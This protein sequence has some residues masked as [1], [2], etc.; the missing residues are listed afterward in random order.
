MTTSH[1]MRPLRPHAATSASYPRV[2]A[3]AWDDIAD[4]AACGRMVARPDEARPS[5][6]SSRGDED[7]GFAVSDFPNKTRCYTA[8]ARDNGDSPSRRLL[9]ENGCACRA[10]APE[11]IGAM[12]AALAHPARSERCRSAIS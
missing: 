8:R 9:H 3:R 12:Q 6:G 2:C 7:D 5:D 11:N 10:L 1:S 4:V